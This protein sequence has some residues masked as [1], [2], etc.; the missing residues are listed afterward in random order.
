MTVCWRVLR[1]SRARV[2][3][4]WVWLAERLGSHENTGECP[5][6]DSKMRPATVAA[7]SKVHNYA[8]S[9]FRRNPAVSV[10]VISWS[11]GFGLGKD[12]SVSLPKC[13]AVSWH[14][15]STG[16]MA[17]QFRH[18]GGSMR[19]VLIGAAV[20]ACLLTSRAV[21]WGHPGHDHWQDAPGWKESSLSHAP[22]QQPAAGPD[23]S[24]LTATIIGA[25]VGLC[26]FLAGRHV[27]RSAV[28]L[29]PALA[30]SALLLVFIGCGD[31]G[32][33]MSDIHPQA[34]HDVKQLADLFEHFKTDGVTFRSDEDFFYIESN[35]FPRHMMMVGITA[36]Q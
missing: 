21:L 20:F 18:W 34:K 9:D 23:T 36:W 8:K 16:A 32:K 15:W 33:G 11:V 17:G 1:R 35:A 13:S 2:E 6:R 22:V 4:W 3:S 30:V 28:V 14:G 10:Q 31:G 7:G 12:R 5:T 29:A 24:V 26:M 27:K 19:S 25:A